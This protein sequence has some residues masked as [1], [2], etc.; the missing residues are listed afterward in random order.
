MLASSSNAFRP[1]WTL[2]TFTFPERF[3]AVTASRGL[4]PLTEA[5]ARRPKAHRWPPPG[6][7]NALSS[8]PG[9]LAPAAPDCVPPTQGDGKDGPGL[10]ARHE[11]NTNH[12]TGNG[13]MGNSG[14]GAVGYSRHGD[15]GHSGNGDV[16]HSEN[17]GVG[18][19]GNGN[20]GHSGNGGVGH[21]G[22][23]DLG[24]SGFEGES[25][26]MG[27]M[28][29]SR[30]EGESQP[31]E[32]K[33]GLASGGEADLEARLMRTPAYTRLRIPNLAAGLDSWDS[34]FCTRCLV[35]STF[36]VLLWYCCSTHA[37]L[38]RFQFCHCTVT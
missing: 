24:Q 15:M 11:Q 1:Q 31:L 25:Q 26:P 21:S 28:G 10:E 14:N 3:D 5:E 4:F 34:L 20:L 37:L 6:R 13:A 23:G 38:L 16:G 32:A 9:S 19:A 30:A 8:A 33:E 7:A 12:C 2:E 17:G 18:H 22:N 36:V 35:S 29:H 27:A